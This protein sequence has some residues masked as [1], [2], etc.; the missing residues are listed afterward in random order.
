MPVVIVERAPEYSR[1]A[2]KRK[3]EGTVTIEVIVDEEGLPSDF[4]VVKSLGYG[5]DENALAAARLYRF[6]PA[7]LN[8]K[9]V[10][11]RTS[12]KVD[13]RLQMK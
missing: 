4:H 8:G 7:T 9:S 6:R 1:E 2:R 11:V 3:I 5:L 13:F 10:A 12:I